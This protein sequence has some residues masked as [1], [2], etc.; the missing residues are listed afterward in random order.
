MARLWSSRQPS[1]VSH[2]LGQPVSA[3]NRSLDA[4]TLNGN[5]DW[6]EAI[7]ERSAGIPLDVTLTFEKIDLDARSLIASVFAREALRSL[8]LQLRPFSSPQSTAIRAHDRAFTMSRCLAYRALRI[9]T[10]P[11]KR[12]HQYASLTP[13]ESPSVVGAAISAYMS[14]S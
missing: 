3:H 2:C 8:V 10:S 5:R 9:S 13:M 11:A 1:M 7:I 12:H 6:I 14:H 4:D